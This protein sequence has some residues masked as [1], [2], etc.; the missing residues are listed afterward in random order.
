MY[1]LKR[2][3]FIA[4]AAPSLFIP[5][6]AKVCTDYDT[7]KATL[8]KNFHS[9]R[10]LFAQKINKW[11]DGF[12]AYSGKVYADQYWYFRTTPCE[13]NFA[14]D[15]PC[16]VIIN[17]HS[18]RRVFAQ[19]GNRSVGAAPSGKVWA[20]QK[21]VLEETDC[22]GSQCYYIINAHSG[23]R[24]FAQSYEGGGKVGAY[25]GKKYADQKWFI[26]ICDTCTL[27]KIEI[28]NPD[29][30]QPTYE[31]TQIIGVVTSGSCIGTGS[32]SISLESVDTVEETLGIETSTTDELNY[33]V[34]AS[35]EVEGSA[36][37]LGFGASVTVGVA[38]SVGGSHSWTRSESKDFT[39]GKLVQQK[40]DKHFVV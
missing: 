6:D 2:I 31:G 13:G 9:N 32:H 10:N 11:T 38:A 21:W 25:S 3:L 39:E 20:D 18:H 36:K 4:S 7:K 1:F 5:S 15:G 12:G 24:L 8:I 19:D 30:Y 22:N 17:K 27:N 37:F 28:L 40:G 16:F 14:K 29:L 34:T 33:G 35:V 23:R 26:D